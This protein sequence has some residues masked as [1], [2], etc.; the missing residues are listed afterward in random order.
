MGLLVTV[1][2]KKNAMPARLPAS[3]PA[4]YWEHILGSLEEGI[5][6]IDQ[7]Q[8]VSFINPAAEQLLGLSRPQILT[9]P[10]LEVCIPNPWMNEIV[11]RTVAA[12]SR[13]T[14]GE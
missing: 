10:Y 2:N 9:R 13:P 5:L 12:G 4:D 3:F 11:Q 6:V 1:P 14:A 7:T 8:C